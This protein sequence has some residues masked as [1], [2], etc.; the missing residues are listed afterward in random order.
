MALKEKRLKEILKEAF[1]EGLNDTLVAD[2]LA[3]NGLLYLDGGDIPEEL[4]DEERDA[5][6]EAYIQGFISGEE[7]IGLDNILAKYL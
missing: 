1:D 5:V 3:E 2:I 4:T 7:V 6:L